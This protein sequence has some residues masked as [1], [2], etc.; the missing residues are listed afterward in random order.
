V[1]R[2][3]PA[4]QPSRL[5]VLHGETR[6]SRLPQGEPVPRDAAPV[7]PAWL[8]ADARAVWDRT[9]AELAAMGMCHAADTDSLVVYCTAVVNHARAQQLIDAGGVLLKGVEG[10]VVRSP[11]VAVVH[12]AS[13][14]INR[15]A[16]EFGLTPSARVSL[17]RPP[18]DLMGT[19]AAAERL[20][21]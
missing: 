15:Y 6:P 5:K 2:R 14:V 4:P 3:G 8:S 18:A 9:T 20:L 13:V 21:S 19:R 12:A 1:G 16:R 10:G 7:P 17:G 11:A